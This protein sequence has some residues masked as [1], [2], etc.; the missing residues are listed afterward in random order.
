MISKRDVIA[1]AGGAG[2]FGEDPVISPIDGAAIGRA[3]LP[4]VYEGEAVFHIGRTRQTSLREQYPVAMYV[5][6]QFSLPEIVEE[7]E[8]V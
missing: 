4:L 6:D 5:G 7:P 3:N 8:I 1:Y 2:G